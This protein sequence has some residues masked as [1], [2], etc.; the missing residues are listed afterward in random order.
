[1]DDIQVIFVFLL[2][3]FPRGCFK[4]KYFSLVQNNELGD[5]AITIKYLWILFDF[6]FH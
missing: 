1:M 5:G 2:L 3:N 4:T 6:I